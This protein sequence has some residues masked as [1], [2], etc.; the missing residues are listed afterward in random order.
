MD[1]TLILDSCVDNML[2]GRQKQDDIDTLVQMPTLSFNLFSIMWS[3][4]KPFIGMRLLIPESHT[5]AISF[6][7]H[8]VGVDLDM[9]D[10]FK[11][12]FCHSNMLLHGI[13][14]QCNEGCTMLD[15]SL[16]DTMP[17]DV[18]FVDRVMMYT[19]Y[20]NNGIEVDYL[21]H[22]YALMRSGGVLVALLPNVPVCHAKLMALYNV[23]PDTI[24]VI[25]IS[26][27]QLI[28]SITKP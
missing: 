13:I 9:Y 26:K 21:I 27:Q 24:D 20:D 10:R 19:R 6:C 17:T 15:N 5:L 8:L 25:P 7:T 22:A 23:L 28:I 14:E 18:G 12:L 3:K 1:K 16:L 4:L 11:M 2:A